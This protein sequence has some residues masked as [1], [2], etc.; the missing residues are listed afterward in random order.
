MPTQE[1]ELEKLLSELVNRVARLPENG[2]RKLIGIAGAPASGKSTLAAAL[3]GALKRQGYNAEYVPMDGFHLDNRLLDLD[4]TRAR[5]GAPNTFDA[6]GFLNMVRRL[7]DEEV[8][9][10]PVFDRAQDQA[11]AGAGRVGNDCQIAVIEGN[12][13]LFGA[14]PWRR[15]AGLW[16][17][18][19]WIDTAD[20]TV[21]DRCI[22]RW[23]DHGHTPDAA[24]TRAEENDLKNARLIKDLRLDGDLL[25]GD[26]A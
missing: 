7:R 26:G 24:R 9:H 11:I 12:Y 10:F 22:Q 1:P 6:T 15:L 5:K 13:L 4:G 16:D 21:R 20:E 2:H 8:V 17:L 3:V 23:L 19:I 25:V 14:E 18:S